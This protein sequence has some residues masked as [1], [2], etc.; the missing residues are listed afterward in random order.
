MHF[1]LT[2]EAFLPLLSDLA[3]IVDGK[4]TQPIFNHVWLAAKAGRLTLKSTD[5]E[6]SLTASV[7][8]EIIEEGSITVP[9]VKLLNVVR[10][11]ASETL[12]HCEL[13]EEQFII[14]SDK[15]TVRLVTLPAEDFPLIENEES[16]HYLR[17][18]AAVL[19]RT[20]NKVE[21]SI[22]KE[23]VRYYLNGMHLKVVKDGHALHTVSTDGHRLSCAEM[24]LLEKIEDELSLILPKKAVRELTKLLSR[25]EGEVSLALS[26]REIQFSS[27]DYHLTSRLIDGRF[28]NYE[29]VLP[30]EVDTP[31]LIE[32]QTLL[33]SLELAKVLLVDKHDGVRLRFEGQQL[34]LS[35]RNIDNETIEDEI[36]IINPETI[37]LET[38]FNI[39]YLFEVVRNLQGHNI[40][41]HLSGAESPCLFTAE[42][43]VGVRYVIMPMRL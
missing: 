30:K 3:S 36:A 21:F 18:E 4:T 28:P 6:L 23:D 9:A 27:G 34:F 40:Q 10:N 32:R 2:K 16:S 13:I 19:Q 24:P 42:S 1:S 25:S 15:G 37:S 35:G 17:V 41:L 29:N 14:T 12:V 39:N 38:A 20:M 5:S 7:A 11:I 33:K 22:A 31:I 43:D 26:S 8:A